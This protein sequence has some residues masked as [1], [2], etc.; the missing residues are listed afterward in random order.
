MKYYST[1]KLPMIVM[2]LL[3]LPSC[4]T[5]GDKEL[6]LEDIDSGNQPQLEEQVSL[7]PRPMMKAKKHLLLKLIP[8]IVMENCHQLHS[9]VNA[10]KRLVL[11][12]RHKKL[13]RK[14]W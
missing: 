1:I 11:H 5:Q 3:S 8:N 4:I 2:L 6:E 14:L 7:S 10:L 13:F 9:L 12:R